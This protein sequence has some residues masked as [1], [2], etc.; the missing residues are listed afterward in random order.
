MSASTTQKIDIVRVPHSKIDTVDITNLSFGS[1]FTDHMLWCDFKEGKWQQPVIKPYEPFLLDP[2]AKV[3]HYGQAIFEGMK[4]YK[5]EQ[6]EVWLFRPDQNFDRFNH[7]AV[8]MAMPEVPEEI[9]MEGLKQLID[10]ELVL[11]KLRVI[12]RRNFIPPNW[13]TTKATN[14]SFGPTMP[15]TPNWKKPVP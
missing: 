10:L 2:S 9:F 11:P 1:T 8:R 7:S 14:K 3:F 4:A 13:P 15:H 12:I 6:D 5:D